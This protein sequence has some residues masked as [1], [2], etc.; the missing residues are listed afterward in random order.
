MIAENTRDIPVV[1][2]RQTEYQFVLFH[3][4]AFCASG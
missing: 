4:I 3:S 2:L 1:T